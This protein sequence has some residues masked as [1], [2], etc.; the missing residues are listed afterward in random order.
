MI[1]F[2][3]EQLL[4]SKLYG[5]VIVV[6]FR[7]PNDLKFDNPETQSKFSNLR[8][9]TFPIELVGPKVQIPGTDQ[10]MPGKRE[11]F[12]AMNVENLIV[13]NVSP[14]LSRSDASSCYHHF[15]A[16]NEHKAAAF[17]SL[18]DAV[19]AKLKLVQ[20]GVV[21]D[22]LEILVSLIGAEETLKLVKMI[23]SG[24]GNDGTNNFLYPFYGH[25]DFG[26]TQSHG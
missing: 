20:V 26:L 10:F 21:I 22:R 24:S 9:A 6:S 5:S 25:V 2:Q 16:L 18:I 17:K 23:K 13:L 1:N 8:Q 11:R 12:Q 15:R 4:A 3:I 7:N 14:T 19:V